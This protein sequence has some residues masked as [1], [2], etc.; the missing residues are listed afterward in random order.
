MELEYDV[1]EEDEHMLRTNGQHVITQGRVILENIALLKKLT[2]M[3][4]RTFIYQEKV[5]LYYFNFD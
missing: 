4:D 3:F 1:E 5:L 2:P